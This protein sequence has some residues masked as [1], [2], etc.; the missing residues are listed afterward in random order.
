MLKCHNLDLHVSSPCLLSLSSLPHCLDAKPVRRLLPRYQDR[1][2][3]GV[4]SGVQG[5]D[6][7]ERDSGDFLGS[8][9]W[10]IQRHERER[11]DSR[12][13]RDGSD[14]ERRRRKRGRA[15]KRGLSGSPCLL[16]ERRAGRLLALPPRHATCRFHTT[17]GLGA[18]SAATTISPSSRSGNT[19]GA[20]APRR[21]RPPA[22]EGT[23]AAAL[24]RAALAF[25]ASATRSLTELDDEPLGAEPNG[26][27][28]GTRIKI[29]HV[30]VPLISRARG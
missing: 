3:R 7:K 19:S 25:S 10:W 29:A 17:A 24:T 13:E 18:A 2:R 4:H 23:T 21:R 6:E 5:D 8:G 28:P 30:G 20:T 11:E 16:R 12:E 27:C 9:G 15:D 22:G 14:G 26:G 1:R